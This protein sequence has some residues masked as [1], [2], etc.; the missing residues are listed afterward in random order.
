MIRIPFDDFFDHLVVFFFRM[1]LIKFKFSFDMNDQ[2]L[3]PA[4]HKRMNSFK[5]EDTKNIFL[6]R[7]YAW[8]IISL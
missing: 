1:S 3:K 2:L 7:L 6:C 8:G 5:R 4:I